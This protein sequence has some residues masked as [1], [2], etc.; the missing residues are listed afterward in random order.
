MRW[1]ARLCSNSSAKLSVIPSLAHALRPCCR[2]SDSRVAL[3]SSVIVTGTASCDAPGSFRR[4]ATSAALRATASERRPSASTRSTTSWRIEMPV[5]SITRASGAGLKGA[6]ARVESLRS[7]SAISRERAAKANTGP[8]VFQLL[9]A[10]AGPLFGAGGQ[11]YLQRGVRG[12][13]PCPCRARRRPGPGARRRP[14][15]APAAP[16][17]TAGQAATREA[18]GPGA[19]R[20]EAAVTSSPRAAPARSPRAGAEVAP[21]S[22]RRA[23]A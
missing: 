23:A 1:L 14:A 3:R 11:E 20:A 9:I 5:E 2:D 22:R 12:R 21:P 13:P 7:R 19:L 10:P 17:R 18:P 6:T 4:I 16:A 15:G 8:L